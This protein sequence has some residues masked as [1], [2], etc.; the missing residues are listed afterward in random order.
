[1]NTQHAGTQHSTQ[2]TAH[3]Y[4]TCIELNLAQPYFKGSFLSTV[5]CLS[6]YLRKFVV[7]VFCSHYRFTPVTRHCSHNELLHFCFSLQVSSFRTIRTTSRQRAFLIL[8][9]LKGFVEALRARIHFPSSKAFPL[10]LLV[11][12]LGLLS[13]HLFTI[14]SCFI[15]HSSTIHPLYPDTLFLSSMQLFLSPSSICNV[16]MQL[17]QI[18]VKVNSSKVPTTTCM[19]F[20]FLEI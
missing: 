11:L 14:I 1:M 2:H 16:N 6:C 8:P 15:L 19:P 13:H 4:S 5:H 20:S 12:P 7:N 9:V 3:R 10:P 17:I 18:M